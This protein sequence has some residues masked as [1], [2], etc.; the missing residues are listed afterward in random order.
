MLHLYVLN[1]VASIIRCLEFLFFARALMS[2]FAQGRDSRI[3]EF[4]YLVTEPIILPFRR[5]FER[6]DALR[7]F[8][9]DIPFLVAF[10]ALELILTLLY[11]L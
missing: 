9:F 1:F 11:N 10:F 5:L 8:P 7:G 6:V 3:Y 4:L 2:W